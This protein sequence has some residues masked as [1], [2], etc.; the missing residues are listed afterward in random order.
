MVL[1]QR[2]GVAIAPCLLLLAL[3][4]TSAAA[5]TIPTCGAVNPCGGGDNEFSAQLGG[6]GSFSSEPGNRLS[7]GELGSAKLIFNWDGANTLTVSVLN[8]TQSA[9]VDWDAVLQSF[10]FSTQDNVSGLTLLSVAYPSARFPGCVRNESVDET[11]GPSNGSLSSAD[12]WNLC[13]D[14]KADGFGTHDWRV[15]TTNCGAKGGNDGLISDAV[16]DGCA[17]FTFDVQFVDPSIATDCDLRDFSVPPPTD[18]LTEFVVKFQAATNGGSGFVGPCGEDLFVELA[19]FETTPGDGKVTVDWETTLEIDNQ[20]FYIWRADLVAGTIERVSGFLPALAANN[21]GASYSFTDDTPVNGVEY[22]YFLEDVDLFN[23][24]SFHP[25]V[26]AIANPQSPRI[27][28]RLPAYGEDVPGDERLTV[29]FEDQG[30]GYYVIFSADPG[31]GDR[32]EVLSVRAPHAGDVTL[33]RRQMGRL[34]EL[35]ASNDGYVYWRVLEIG[36]GSSVSTSQ[37][38]RF[39]VTESELTTHGNVFGRQGSAR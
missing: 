6:E 7:A 29:R 33:N 22:T 5:E 38:W 39:Q 36:P 19:R 12:G 31:F 18:R 1:T 26:G 10:Y 3:V 9:T 14:E 17:D 28:L 16:G 34:N 13:D 21:S 35:A 27:Q 37:V 24:T 4:A 30:F 23:V 2:M 11:A 8:N 15:T 20:G 25:A 32:T